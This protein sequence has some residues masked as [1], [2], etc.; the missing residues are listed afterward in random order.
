MDLIW[1]W[2]DALPHLDTYIF[3][4]SILPGRTSKQCFSTPTLTEL[5]FVVNI[6]TCLPLVQN[7][8]T[9]TGEIFPGVSD[10]DSSFKGLKSE[11][12][13]RLS[14]FRITRFFQFEHWTCMSGCTL[15]T[16]HFKEVTETVTSWKQFFSQLATL[17]DHFRSWTKTTCYRNYQS[18]TSNHPVGLIFCQT[19]ITY[20]LEKSRWSR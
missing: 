9:S 12:N 13:K 3:N 1:F 20:Q 7:I 15:N 8:C 16:L 14:C 18:L 6:S 19:L 10:M 5:H 2:F 11:H 17:N 4:R